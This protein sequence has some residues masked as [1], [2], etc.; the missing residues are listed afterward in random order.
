MLQNTGHNTGSQQVRHSQNAAWYMALIVILM[1]GTVIWAVLTLRVDLFTERVK[2]QDLLNILLVIDDGEKP[3]LTEMLMIY[4]E[5]GLSALI[6]IPEETGGL[7]STVDR[8]DRLESLYNPENLEVY[9]AEAGKLLGVSPDFRIR[10]S[11]DN[12]EK[13]VD[14]AGGIDIFI[15]NAVDDTVENR[16]YLFPPGGVSLDG[17][18]A[19]SY[20]EYLPEGEVIDK[21]TGREHRV[22]QALLS[23]LGSKGRYLTSEE[24]YPFVLSVFDTNL[25]DKGLVSLLTFLE[26]LDT[27]RTIFQGV[28]GNRRLLDGQT[29]LF[30]HYEG[31]LIRETV[32]R[33]AET[34][35]KAGTFGE[36]LL[37]VRVEI[38]NGTQVTGLASRTAQ[39][40]RSY[41]FRLSSVT[42]A[43]RND[44]EQ[45][46][47]L[48]RRG[49]PDAARQVAELIRCGR[50]HSRIDENRD[51]TVDVTVILGKDFDGRYVK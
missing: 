46:V 20:L 27:G 44:Y 6:N 33:V 7:L 29:V 30:P 11:A 24:V 22:V 8:V 47:V 41:G 10:L 45:T 28:L 25:D 18:K 40:F 16:R 14:L 48:D 34:L 19:R 49:N 51:E 32:Q 2:N 5:T 17:A 4:P 3:L 12:F 15:P 42:N 35:A 39:I 31:K 50:I 37:T 13:L 43:D 26:T 21:R 38:L 1:A 9:E 23:S 36:K